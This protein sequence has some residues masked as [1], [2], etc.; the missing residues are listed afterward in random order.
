MKHSILRQ[1]S[2]LTFSPVMH[3]KLPSSTNPNSGLKVAELTMSEHLLYLFLCIFIGNIYAQTQAASV[4]NPYEYKLHN[5]EGHCAS[6]GTCTYTLKIPTVDAIDRGDNATSQ[7]VVSHLFQHDKQIEQL[8]G[9]FG[10]N[11]TG[12]LNVI[13]ELNL[14]KEESKTLN[15][16]VT[17]LTDE[18]NRLLKENANLNGQLHAVN[19]TLLS[20]LAGSVITQ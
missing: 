1:Y 20:R 17:I 8:L 3:E 7:A 4:V 10:G 15:N 12:Q 18:V 6:D 16:L 2:Y 5:F 9:Y 13:N 14:I 11:A 19:N